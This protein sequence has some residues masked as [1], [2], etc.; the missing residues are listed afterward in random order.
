MSTGK[1]SSSSATARDS[2]A[3]GAMQRHLWRGPV[4]MLSPLCFLI[5]R[6]FHWLY[7][8]YYGISTYR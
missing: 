4:F 3:P 6:E 7:R 2:T 8:G 5:L 1:D